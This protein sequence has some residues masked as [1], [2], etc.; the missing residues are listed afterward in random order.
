[1]V[2]PRPSTGAKLQAYSTDVLIVIPSEMSSVTELATSPV[3]LPD[4]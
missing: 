2:H 1:M 3:D 4:R